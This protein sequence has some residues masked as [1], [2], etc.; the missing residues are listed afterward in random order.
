MAQIIFKGRAEQINHKF[1][2]VV[3]LSTQMLPRPPLPLLCFPLHF[4]LLFFFFF[5]FQT[6]FQVV[7]TLIPLGE[8]KHSWA[9]FPHFGAKPQGRT[10]DGPFLCHMSIGVLGQL[11][12]G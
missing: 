9:N 12:P 8:Y 10:L 4:D 6:H 11:M 2:E 7:P 1:G 3:L 5:F